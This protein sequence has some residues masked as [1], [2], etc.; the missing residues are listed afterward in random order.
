MAGNFTEDAK[1]HWDSI[2]S[3]IQEQLINNVF[4][5][6]C[7]LTSIVDFTG[8]M[9]GVDLILEGSCKKCGGKV[10]RLIEGD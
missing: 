10:A 9:D 4:C 6:R 1:K 3:D 7:K 2:P 5:V 8:K